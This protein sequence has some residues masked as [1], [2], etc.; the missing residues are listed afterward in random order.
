MFP[1]MLSVRDR[2]CLVV[3]GGGVAL[4]KAD[5]LLAEGARI[6]VVTPRAV[7]PLERLARERRITL[8]R[9]A[10]R[11]GEA[12]GYTLVFATTDDP[13]VNRQVF[14]DANGAGIPVNVADVPELCTFHVPAV[15]RRGPLRLAI[16]SEG[17]APF[18]V[19]RLRQV[20]ERRL[21]P[22]WAEWMQA[23]GRF[24]QRV[25][26]LSAGRA[27][28][29][30]LFDS[31]FERS[32]DG[33]SLSVRVPTEDDLRGILGTLAEAPA[34]HGREEARADPAPGMT[35]GFVSLV[36]AGPGCP[37][38]ITVRG[39][40]RLLAADA[41]VYD[42]LAA[43]ALPP[44]LP[45]SVELHPVGKRPGHHPVPQEEISALLIR[46]AQ[47]GKRV[48]RLKGGDPLVFGRGGEEA[49][50]LARMGVPF[51]IVPGITA[52]IGATAFAGIPVTHRREAV[53]VTFVTAHECS[54]RGGPQIRWDLLAQD[55]HG[56]IVGYMG[57]TTLPAVT[58]SLL[59]AG[60]DP[61]TPAALVERG[62]TSR[63]RSVRATLGSL[64]R[65]A[66]ETGIR[67][68]AL[69][70]IGP[71][72][73][74]ADRLN[75]FGRLPLAG[76]RILVPEDLRRLAEGLELRGAE[77]VVVPVPLTPAARV[78]V[79]AQPLTD[80]LV[81]SPAEAEAFDGQRD[82]PGWSRNVT[83]W[84]LGGR[85]ARRAAELGWAR[86]VQLEEGADADI[87]RERLERQLEK[88]G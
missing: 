1:V 16:A 48:V 83:V 25:R 61:D 15:I 57:V 63:Q 81:G 71:T 10:Y 24:R 39:Y 50:A 32:M 31:F 22:E 11:P 75:W 87:L 34:G 76:R 74:R 42:R 72:V 20:L 7:E 4:R 19:R 9:R 21:G 68:P 35:G 18:A 55:P 77:V 44:G 37:G 23:A 8:E 40:R 80:C 41:V 26:A 43:P 66:K 51:E 65:T 3:G 36:G 59:E 52:G 30:A 62:S 46:L 82:S 29:E 79:A 85:A 53:R 12:A 56:T 78:V 5:G 70:V 47:T 17:E 49:E 33:G 13:K 38:L 84:A 69:F 67:P 86:V 45:A 64:A 60:M 27:L 2:P 88:A 54:K 28:R 14:A 58:R 6:T 73:E